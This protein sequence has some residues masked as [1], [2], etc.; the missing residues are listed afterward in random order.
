MI[1]PIG[2]KIFEKNSTFTYDK[3]NSQHR[4]REGMLFNIKGIYENLWL[5]HSIV[6][7][8]KLFFSDWQKDEDAHSHHI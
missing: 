6:R 2:R 7:E 3:E 4:G 5:T 8:Q 1:A